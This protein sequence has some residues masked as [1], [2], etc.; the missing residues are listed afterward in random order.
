MIDPNTTG[1]SVQT[2]HNASLVLHEDSEKKKMGW[3]QSKWSGILSS[4][5]WC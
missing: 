1:W 2:C 3:C 4:R 5:S